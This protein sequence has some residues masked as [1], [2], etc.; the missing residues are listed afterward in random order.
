ML[1]LCSRNIKIRLGL[2]IFYK[3]T[4]FEKAYTYSKKDLRIKNSIKSLKGISNSEFYEKFYCKVKNN[5]DVKIKNAEFCFFRD[6]SVLTLF[7]VIILFILNVF[8]SSQ[9]KYLFIVTL[10]IYIILVCISWRAAK[11]F[12]SQIL[13]SK[14]E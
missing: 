3:L 14:K 6:C 2:G 10:I 12:V 8:I 7:K 13:L 11:D 5:E 4:P 9:I 1:F